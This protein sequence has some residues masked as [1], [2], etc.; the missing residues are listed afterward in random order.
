MAALGARVPECLAIAAAWRVGTRKDPGRAV[1]LIRAINDGPGPQFLG[2]AS[3]EHLRNLTHIA[4][5]A[6]G[7]RLPVELTGRDQP[8]FTAA[9]SVLL[10]APAE[11][12][13]GYLEMLA[14]E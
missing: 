10:A 5:A 6:R 8:L 4:A 7:G 1:R 2:E 3:S 12:V 13:D 11:V 9:V 14:E